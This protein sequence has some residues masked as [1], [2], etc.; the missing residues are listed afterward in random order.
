MENSNLITQKGQE[1]MDKKAKE[2][3]D[4]ELKK[5]LDELPAG[6]EIPQAVQAMMKAD[7]EEYV[8]Q[9]AE[10]SEQLDKLQD[11]YKALMQQNE[12]EFQEL[13]KDMNI[14]SLIKKIGEMSE[15]AQKVGNEKAVAHYDHLIKEI[16]SSITLDF[17][18]DGLRKIKNTRK[19]MDGAEAGYK[20]EMT[21]LRQKLG[22]NRQYFFNDPA[23]LLHKLAGHVPSE[24]AAIFL[25]SFARFVNSKGQEGI[26][27]YSI[28]IS[29]LI[30]NIYALDEGFEG[31]DELIHSVTVYV[32]SL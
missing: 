32:D 30:K 19:L 29:Q 16:Q 27:K 23:Q 15:L 8:K 10:I 12:K 7:F 28:F 24:T 2:F 1:L 6:A 14:K 22:N 9:D 5:V 13:M 21:K 17:M 4:N 25:F 20:S 3:T 11:D 26:S 31:K 18:V